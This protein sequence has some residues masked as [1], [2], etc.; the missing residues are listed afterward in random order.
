MRRKNRFS[1]RILA[2]ALLAVMLAGPVLEVSA[3]SISD[4]KDKINQHQNQLDNINDKIGTLTDE[5]DII[6]EKIDDLNA[7]IINIMASIGMMEEAITVK[8]QEIT[9]KQ[10][11]IQVTQ[12]EYEAAKLQQENQQKDMNVRARI[13]Y[14]SNKS[15][16][17]NLILS[18]EGLGDILNRMDFVEKIFSYDKSK[19]EEYEDT[20]TRVHELW[21]RLEAEKSSLENDKAALE[22]DRALLQEQRKELDTMLAQKKKESANYEAEIK[23]AQ[24]EAA[25]TKKLLQQEQK[26]LKKLEQAA[27]MAN[28][29]F[30]NT[31][32]T[33]IIDGATGSALGKQIAKYGCQ[34]IGNPYVY[35]GTSLTKGADCSGFTYRIYADFGYTIS[36]TSFLQR[37][38]GKGVSYSEAQPGD[39]ICYDGHVG[40]YIGDGKIVHASNKKSGIKVSNATYRTILAVRRIV[41]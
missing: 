37:S 8:E 6:L 5:Q 32:Y 25:V 12:A 23:K 34:F 7:E 28:K 22:T 17:L 15:T 35:G 24:Q 3:T 2:V 33:S 29:N 30:N 20:K 26:E 41:E 21:D 1:K 18:G 11:Q 14:E 27:A 19:L 38:A 40:M 16:Y 39:L 4:I 31:S 36:R 9:D 10:G 13:L